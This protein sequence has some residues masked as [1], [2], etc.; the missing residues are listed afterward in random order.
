MKNTFFFVFIFLLSVFNSCAQDNEIRLI[1]RADDIGSS[2][3][4]NVACIDVYKDGIARSVEIMVPCP[5]FLEAVEML[6][7]V[8][9]YDVGVHLTM[10]SEWENIK[11]G[12]VSDAPSLTDENGYFYPTFWP[13]DNF[14]VER[15]FTHSNWTPADVEKELRAQI[16]MAIKHLP[17]VSHMGIHMGGT[18]ADPRIA[19]IHEKLAKEYD[20]I[21]S[22]EP[23]GVQRFD[24]FRRA[25]TVEEKICNLVD[26][27]ENL[28]PGTYMF[29]DHP[30]YD[31]PEMRAIGHEGYY[32]VAEDRDGVTKAWT[33]E[34]VK[35]VIERRGVKLISYADLKE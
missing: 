30:G 4:A 13:G 31:T 25:K 22:L 35:E 20:L 19:E 3:T 10:T 18:S 21:T 15:T 34:K 9:G 24:G 11:W 2:H 5:W 17:N 6:K 16:E 7:E 8:P 32:H 12:P 23:Y 14:P 33:D 1:V 29:I 28:K 27:L 26:G